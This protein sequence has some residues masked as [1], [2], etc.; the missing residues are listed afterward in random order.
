MEPKVKIARANA[1]VR[2]HQ[3]D[4]SSVTDPLA[5]FLAPDLSDALKQAQ[6]YQAQEEE[7]ARTLEE[8]RKA[9]LS[10]NG[11]VQ[12]LVE[13]V[14][15]LPVGAVPGEPSPAPSPA[16]PPASAPPAAAEAP[17]PAPVPE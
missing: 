15:R 7:A 8:V 14:S 17:A 6:Q 16:P 1:L 2:A 13:Q 11:R 5:R 10:H 12:Q 3:K 4:P 9:A